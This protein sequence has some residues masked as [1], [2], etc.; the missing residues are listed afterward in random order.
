MTGPGARRVPQR[1]RSRTTSCGS[2]PASRS[3]R[4]AAP[5]PAGV[6]DDLIAYVN[7]DDDVFLVPNA[8][9]TAELVAPARGRRR[10][11]A[12]ERARSAPRV[13]GPRRAGAAV[14]AGAGGRS[15]CRPTTPTCPTCAPNGRASRVIVCRSGY[16]GERGY[17]LLPRWDAAAELWDALVAARW[18]CRAVSVRATRC[19]PRWAI[20][21]T[22]RTCRPTSARSPPGSAGRS[23]GT[24]PDFWGREA[25]LA[26]RAAPTR[27]L[28]GLRV[29]SRHRPAGHGGARTPTAARVSGTV[30]SG[31]FSPTL[32]AGIALAAA[33]PGATRVTR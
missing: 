18:R 31:T 16:T 5:R 13:R 7:A 29:S 32:G 19:A 24:K 30:T 12:V 15:G 2:N 17:E 9:N 8:A 20:R 23:A 25:L 10:R 6:V 26:E 14:A 1:G 28:W 3:T 21:C 33:L 4:C 11:P 27:L 22:G